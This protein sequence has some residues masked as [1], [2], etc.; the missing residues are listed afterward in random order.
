MEYLLKASAVSII[1]Y[2]TY[3]V[4]LQ[5]DTFF[6]FNRGFLLLGLITSFIIPFLVI[7]IYI[8]YTPTL[9]TNYN[10]S[11]G[12][13]LESTEAPFSAID[14][15]PLVYVTGVLFFSCRFIMQLVSLA[16]LIF[17]NKSE[18]KNGFSFIKIDTN[19]S[20]FSFFNW[21]VYNPNQFNKTELDQIIAHEKVHVHQ[22]HSIDILLTQLTCIVLWFNPLIW[23]YIKNVKQNLEFIADQK[24]QHKF[25]CK[26]SY[27]TTLLKTSMP[28]HQMALTNNFYNSLI[29]KRIVML[30]KSKSKKCNLFKYA[31][32]L[33]LL[34]VFLMGF[35][36]KE[37]YVAK[38]EDKTENRHK[39]LQTLIINKNFTENNFEE[40][41]KQLKLNNVSLL[42][43]NVARNS[44]N[45]II[46][47]TI[48]VENEQGSAGATW[49]NENKPIPDIEV[50]KNK[51]GKVFAR[52][53]FSSVDKKSPLLKNL[54]LPHLNPKNKV[55]QIPTKLNTD[56]QEI[57]T[58]KV[59]ITKDFTDAD[60]KSTIKQAKDNGTTLKFN[61]IKRN[62]NGEITSI[63]ASF[64]NSKGSGNF[65]LNG[66]TPI[67][68]FA[69]YQNDEGFGFGTEIENKV[70]KGRLLSNTK[71]VI[72]RENNKNK[73][74]SV[75]LV[76]EDTLYI[77]N[78]SKA[79]SISKSISPKFH[80][81][82]KTISA[83]S[84]YFGIKKSNLESTSST[85]TDSTKTIK[86]K[87]VTGYGNNEN[88]N[89]LYILDGKQ[90]SK[91]DMKVINPNNIHSL[92]VLKDKSS[93]ALYGDKAKDGVVII[94]TKNDL[95]TEFKVGT[96]L[97]SNK[98]YTFEMNNANK[99]TEGSIDEKTGSI[100]LN[101]HAKL[102]IKESDIGLIFVDGKKSTLKKVEK[103][104]A[105]H[106]ESIIVL[107]GEKAIEKYRD[108]GKNG[109]VEIT[110]KKE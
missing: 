110:T 5:R 63:A 80:Q 87:F 7:P 45:V 95:K 106:I 81:G 32:V 8:E 58:F 99:R 41:K 52:T 4:F 43:D 79:H 54:K 61:K 76:K 18:K 86:S 107:K 29:K 49:E 105:E 83:D 100:T 64:K 68:T 74:S 33:P 47:L 24:A 9:L 15:L 14:Y 36:T 66:N 39:I 23:F 103:L 73:K 40:L 46:K 85:Y 3:K 37:I 27:Q 67:K 35:N 93:T 108:K 89:P 22:Y 71:A 30:H 62:S 98:T 65:N 91:E 26:K 90:I 19:I 42:I 77:I 82:N 84:I 101:G 102:N 72:D 75:F 69:Y 16:K 57:V 21:V 51:N 1:F 59:L 53:V 44:N 55:K 17:K 31:L 20:P 10:F 2:F 60:F 56:I 38:T 92:S 48:K 34:A 104:P 11:E 70:V 13:A 50:G 28:S 78:N 12:I 97:N 109:V 96:P 25:N 94:T 88:A 6:G